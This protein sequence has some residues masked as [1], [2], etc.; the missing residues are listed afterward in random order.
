MKVL[1]LCGSLEK[2]KDGVGDYVRKLSINM[3]GPECSISLLSIMEK[4][5]TDITTEQIKNVYSNINIVRIPKFT[6]KK[7]RR[8]IINQFILQQEPDWISLQFVPFSFND[9]G[10]PIYLHDLFLDIDKSIKW[11]IMFHELWVGINTEASI[12]YKIWGE[13]Q[14]L[15]I[16]DLVKKL[17]PVY[18]STNT[19]V[20]KHVLTSNRIKS[21]KI[22]IFSNIEKKHNVSAHRCDKIS[23]IIFANL[24]KTDKLNDF[25]KDVYEYVLLRNIDIQF[26]FVGK[27]GVHIDEW[28]SLLELYKFSYKVYGMLSGSE[29][30][31]IMNSSSWGISTTPFL[32]I[33]KSGSVVAMREHQ[34]PVICIG[35]AWTYP[36]NFKRNLDFIFEYKKGNLPNLINVYKGNNYLYN[37]GNTVKAYREFLKSY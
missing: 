30:S 26:I 25:L 7:N 14:R 23:M 4:N 6:S 11:H 5:L 1:F 27:N 36:A 10:L 31:E 15:I 13:F 34:L 24:Q 17:K 28:I 8:A 19:D 18:I 22:P 12:K 29:I 9:K 32:Q 33:E 2:D 35:A 20:Y 37:V 3:L 21:E 16:L